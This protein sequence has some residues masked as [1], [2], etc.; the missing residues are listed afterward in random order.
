MNA[1]NNAILHTSLSYLWNGI[2]KTTKKWL[3]T[4][5]SLIIKELRMNQSLKTIDFEKKLKIQKYLSLNPTSNVEHDIRNASQLN[6]FNKR[7]ITWQTM[8]NL[9]I[10]K[11]NYIRG[12]KWFNY[13]DSIWKYDC[14]NQSSTSLLKYHS[15]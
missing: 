4:V 11:K 7:P 15:A 10:F 3:Y 8:N 9:W 5:W 2:V 13:R 1:T 6:L 12:K 14:A